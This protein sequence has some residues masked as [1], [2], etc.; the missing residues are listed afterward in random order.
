MA[1][2]EINKIDIEKSCRYAMLANCL[3]LIFRW[4]GYHAVVLSLDS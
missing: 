4:P 2:E 3:V 1:E